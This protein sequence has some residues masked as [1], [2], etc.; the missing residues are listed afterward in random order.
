[1]VVNDDARSWLE[2]WDKVLQEADGI[3]GGV[4][5]EDPTEVVD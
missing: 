4:V 3:W 1:V 2:R 5:M